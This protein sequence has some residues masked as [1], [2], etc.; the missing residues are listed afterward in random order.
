MAEDAAAA[1]GIQINVPGETGS[2]APHS[3][4][5]FLTLDVIVG[6]EKAKGA[7]KFGTVGA[8]ILDTLSGSSEKMHETFGV[9][10]EVKG[11]LRCYFEAEEVAPAQ[12]SNHD[13]P[14]E[15]AGPACIH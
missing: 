13:A 15:P 4:P 5:S 11:S 14:Q 7:E 6:D 10:R 1:N 3:D 8:E 9:S 2:F 12:Q